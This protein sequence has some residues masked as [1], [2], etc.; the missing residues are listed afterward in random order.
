MFPQEGGHAP[1]IEEAFTA[2]YGTTVCVPAPKRGHPPET[3]GMHSPVKD[4]APPKP[5]EGSP[6]LTRDVRGSMWD[7]GAPKPQ[8]GLTSY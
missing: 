5:K 8:E 7:Q 3:G 1:A 6:A 2:L 4:Q